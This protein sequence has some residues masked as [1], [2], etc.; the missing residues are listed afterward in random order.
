MKNETR[1]LY[2][3]SISFLLIWL[4]TQVSAQ[5]VAASSAP[6]VTCS[7]LMGLS[8]PNTEI[9][10]ATEVSV[11]SAHCNVV[12]VINK[13]VSR[14]DPDHFVY[15]IG[16]ELNL[17]DRWVGRF[18][19][20]GGGGTDGSLG[21][22]LG[23]VGT[24]LASGWAVATDDG[25]HEDAPGN[26]L[27]GWVDDDPN[28]GGSA[29][30]GVDEQARVEFG[31]EGIEKT[32]LISKAIIASYYG[33]GAQYSYLCGC[34]NGG[35]DAMVA[36]QREPDFFDGIIAGN[37]GFDLPR[38]GVAEAWNEVQLAPLATHTD[39]NDQPYVAD[40]FPYQDLEVASAA[41]L[42]ACDALDG[43]VDGIIDNYTECTNKRVYAA[44]DEYTCSAG[45]SHGNTPHAGT[46]LMEAQ[47]TALKNIYAGP[48]N[49][50]GQSL[51]SSWFWDAGIWDPLVAF[52]AGFGLWNVA[53]PG[54]PGPTNTAI[55]LTLGAG[56]IPM[57]FTTPPAVT[58][59][60]GPGGQEAFIFNYDFDND[61][62]KI[63]SSAPSYRQSAMDFMTALQFMDHGHANLTPFARHGG[64]LIIYDSINDGI[65]SAV[66]LVNWYSSLLPAR[67]GPEG[68]RREGIAGD[69][70]R[71]YLVPNMAHCGGGPA[72]DS[73]G[74]NL[75]TAITS[76]VEH[77]IA[78]GAVVAA[79]TSP[80]SPFPPGAPFDPQV[81]QN[82]PTG[83]TRPLCPYPQQ[84]RYSGT[85]ATNDAANFICV[86]PGDPHRNLER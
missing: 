38:A 23:F 5:G 39:A 55:N 2:S 79:N 56:A 64:K 28:A 67:R 48:K 30:F 76:W 74:P 57:V 21:N 50:R 19:M 15:G 47:V 59:V 35:R 40:T 8:L 45:G 9:I 14:Q 60:Q 81:A 7:S 12:G 65:F 25:G 85:G 22:P 11:P 17:P 72:T 4:S 34:S 66:D 80:T 27:L 16:F 54:P 1:A 36:S 86:N 37:P 52:G 43:L 61:A 75:L 78:P 20:M 32:T 33:A 82:F 24:E 68:D 42:S 53:L 71:M 69:Y 58:P 51:Y 41:I 46:C 13:R 83:G 3:V 73:F 77:D 84:S 10:S 18:E 31:Y 70:I 49:S 29:H 62:P 6:K 44:L 63:F 26:P